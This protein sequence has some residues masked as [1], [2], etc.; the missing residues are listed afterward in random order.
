[1]CNRTS[2]LSCRVAQL[3]EA[4]SGF[5]PPSHPPDAAAPLTGLPKSASLLLRDRS[6]AVLGEEAELHV[7]GRRF[8]QVV[9]ALSIEIDSVC[10]NLA[11]E[12]GA[13][14]DA[15]AGAISRTLTDSKA[16]QFASASLSVRFLRV[17]ALSRSPP[18]S[19]GRARA[20]RGLKPSYKVER[21]SSR[22]ESYFPGDEDD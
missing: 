5:A 7:V 2:P 3:P 21:P 1:M 18:L 17:R 13:L 16:A 14:P 12:D 9:G 6:T 20:T 10:V 4:D 11:S 15:A 8:T 19:A 22:N